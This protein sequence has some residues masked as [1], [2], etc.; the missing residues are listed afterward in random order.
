MREQECLYSERNILRPDFQESEDIHLKAM[1]ETVKCV[2]RPSLEYANEQLKALKE[3][4]KCVY[5]P[6][7]EYANEQSFSF[8]RNTL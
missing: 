4:V 5:R 6:P 7:L 2:Y 8:Q 3:T 1:K